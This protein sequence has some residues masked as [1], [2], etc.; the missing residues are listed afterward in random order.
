[1]GNFSARLYGARKKFE[2]AKSSIH[3]LNASEFL[4]AQLGSIVSVLESVTKV[5]AKVDY[6][7]L[8]LKTVESSNFTAVQRSI[9]TAVKDLFDQPLHYKVFADPMDETEGH[10]ARVFRVKFHD[11]PSLDSMKRLVRHLHCHHGFTA[12]AAPIE[13]EIAWQLIDSLGALELA[14]LIPKLAS[15][16]S[17]PRIYA[18]HLWVMPQSTAQLEQLLEDDWV[19]SFGHNETAKNPSPYTHRFYFKKTDNGGQP[20]N[21]AKWHARFELTLREAYMREHYQS[22]DMLKEMTAKEVMEKVKLRQV[23]ELDMSPELPLHVRALHHA[24]ASLG[25]QVDALSWCAPKGKRVFSKWTESCREDDKRLRDA[26]TNLLARWL[27]PGQSSS[28][29]DAFLMNWQ[30]F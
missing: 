9:N 30:G 24:R 18:K 13:L 3:I 14:R 25:Q 17:E 2:S 1:M 11:V 5:S 27:R 16:L 23:K 20:L 7:M 28:G 12:Y 29:F 6:L 8:E 19:V 22:L 21:P 4:F 15:G 26:V 10:S